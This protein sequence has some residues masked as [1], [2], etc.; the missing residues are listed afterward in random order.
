MRNERTTAAANRSGASSEK[1]VS[2]IAVSTKERAQ[3]FGAKTSSPYFAPFSVVHRKLLETDASFKE[4]FKF[5][6][7]ICP[8]YFELLRLSSDLDRRSRR[9][10]LRFLVVEK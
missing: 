5:V 8:I 2:L 4:F 10:I 9:I 3:R 7:F 6:L 1:E